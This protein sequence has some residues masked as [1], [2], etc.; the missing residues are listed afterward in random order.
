MTCTYPQHNLCKYRNDCL[1]RY[2]NKETSMI[3]KEIKYYLGVLEDLHSQIKL[4]YNTFDEINDGVYENKRNALG[5]L[6]KKPSD[7]YYNLNLNRIEKDISDTQNTITQLRKKELKLIKTLK[8]SERR[9][10][11]YDF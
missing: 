9:H 3:S 1:F 2:G 4:Y 10:R 5:K 6:I 8:R 11:M 7:V